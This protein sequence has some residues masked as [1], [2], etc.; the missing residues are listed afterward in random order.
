MICR[1]YQLL[2]SVFF[3]SS[4]FLNHFLLYEYVLTN[5][6]RVIC[7]SPPFFLGSS[8]MVC[9]RSNNRSMSGPCIDVNLIFFSQI[10]WIILMKTKVQ[11]YTPTLN[12]FQVISSLNHS[13]F[14]VCFGY[15]ANVLYVSNQPTGPKKK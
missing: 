15:C 8:M 13:F 2:F 5:V 7:Y 6:L 11:C 10:K 14:L 9:L 1:D 4:F 3:G 12:H